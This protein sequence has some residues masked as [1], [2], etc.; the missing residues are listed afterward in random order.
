MVDC[1]HCG[2]S[3]NLDE[4]SVCNRC[5]GNLEIEL[6]SVR[7]L[8][9]DAKQPALL[10][11]GRFIVDGFV[12]EVGPVQ[13]YDVHEVEDETKCY[14]LAVCAKQ[15][16]DPLAEIEFELD[17]NT[18]VLRNGANPFETEFKLLTRFNSPGILRA[19]HCFTDDT[20]AYL[21]LERIEGRRLSDIGRMLESDVR[22]L[23]VE[24]CQIADQFHRQRLTHNGLEPA[25]L[26]IDCQ[27][28]LK[29]IQFERV[30]PAKR[31]NPSV[32]IYVTDGFSAPELYYL[33]EYSILDKRSDIF[34]IGAILYW[35]LTGD[36]LPTG[37][38]NIMRA[39]LWQ[40]YPK[41]V[42]SPA[43]ERII[44]RA[45]AYQPS[46]R[47]NSVNELKYALA[48]LNTPT[49]IQAG[50]ATDVGHQRELNE[51]SILVVD[52][53]QCFE[54][55]NTHIGL[56]IVSDGMGGEAAGEI[57]SRVTVRAVAEWVTDRLISASLR[58]THG[59]QVAEPTQTGSIL[60]ANDTGT[61]VRASQLLT[62][63]IQHANS[64]VLDYAHYHPSTRGLG[65]T[66]TAVLLV[67][68]VLT[69]GQV[70]DSRGYVLSDGQ[71]EQLTEDHSLVERMV[72][73]GEIT[74]Q[75]ARYHPHRNIIYRS[76]G[77][78]DEIEVDI[79]TRVVRR[80]DLVLLCSDG[81]T[82]MLV[83]VEIEEIMG[84]SDDPWHIAKEL[85]VA[86]NARGGDDN[87]SVIV[88]R[89]D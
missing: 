89:V 67:G 69:I 39:E 23:G 4:M 56:Y 16:S 19:T 38:I 86:A 64:E 77:S 80:G 52:L 60:L 35:L 79:I 34:S 58:S 66:V 71:L 83:D 57:A 54:S 49:S 21:V 72:R 20:A 30:R 18:E 24:L 44:M 50:Y 78:R 3:E 87:I 1:P 46:D 76:I 43:L 41:V 65:A 42:V 29:I 45:L 68:N 10:A 11:D 6:S 70:G 37:D 82:N 88:V 5:G 13:Y 36:C 31:Y 62:N 15:V 28:R 55:V 74:P 59:S 26:I 51:D 7:T 17:T 48:G 84:H 9:D 14:T 22:Q 25:G 12:A 73:R 85:V 47:Y 81:L 40:L 27:A 8:T 61:D 63:A 32:P 33:N 75:E 2:F 53:R